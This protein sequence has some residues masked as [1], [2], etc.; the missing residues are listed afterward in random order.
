MKHI[1]KRIWGTLLCLAMLLSLL[2]VTALANGPE[3]SNVAAYTNSS[4]VTTYYKT[5]GAAIS[6]SNSG[7]GGTIKLLKDAEL[8][9]SD[10]AAGD[11][12]S[13]LPYGYGVAVREDL[14]LDLGGNV[15]TCGE[16]F[17]IAIYY[18]KFTIQNGTYRNTCAGGSAIEAGE[19]S[20]VTVEEDAIIEADSDALVCDGKNTVYVYGK[21]YGGNNGVWG[22]GPSN[23]ITL[24]GAYI[25]SQNYAVYQNSSDKT[26]TYFI[27]NST[28]IAGDNS[29][30]VYLNN[31]Q[32]NHI[33]YK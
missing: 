22:Y 33:S 8:K 9:A 23:N 2:P 14:T 12:V 16:F 27:E 3:E 29:P 1:R 19:T 31:N 5:V 11:R 26:S 17:G 25:E 30:G 28:I 6:A 10:A 15:L 13:N 18:V 32:N 21:I 24:D 4:N 7:G 20:T